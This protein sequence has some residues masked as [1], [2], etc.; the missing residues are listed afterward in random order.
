MRRLHPVVLPAKRPANARPASVAR[1]IGPADIVIVN[2]DSVHV[3]R[4]DTTSDLLPDEAAPLSLCSDRVGGEAL[5]VGFGLHVTRVGDM[6]MLR[7]E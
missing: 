5:G 6:L 2:G 4:V 7:V 3:C 1:P